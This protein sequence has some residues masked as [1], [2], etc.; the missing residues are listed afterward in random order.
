MNNI[1]YIK[2]I[3]LKNHNIT[4][5]INITKLSMNDKRRVQ[6]VFFNNDIYWASDNSCQ[7]KK[8]LNLKNSNY[9]W[10]SWSQIKGR[11]QIFCSF[12]KIFSFSEIV[13]PL[14]FNDLMNDNGINFID[15][16]F[17]SIKL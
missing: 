8:Y 17:E 1:E 14:I 9:Y 4:Y 13:R 6:D 16:L 11:F 7:G 2:D 12:S 15:D 10:I 5:Y 3:M